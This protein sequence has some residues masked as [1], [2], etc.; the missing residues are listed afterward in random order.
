[1][2]PFPNTIF[3]RLC[4]LLLFCLSL[5]S[6]SSELDSENLERLLSLSGIDQQTTD[7]A[8]ATEQAL[9][10]L[11][12]VKTQ[13]SA[14]DGA[15]NSLKLEISNPTIVL[16][17]V[18]AELLKTLSNEEAK[19]L[20]KWFESPVGVK[21]ARARTA[22]S[23]N[24][25]LYQQDRNDYL[26][27]AGKERAKLIDE[28]LTESNMVDHAM[29]L[30]ATVGK[31]VAVVSLLPKLKKRFKIAELE[32]Q[33][34][35]QKS[36]MRKLLR[37]QLAQSTLYAYRELTDNELKQHIEMI[38]TPAVQ[39]FHQAMTDGAKHSYESAIVRAIDY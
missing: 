15:V 8:F 2:D 36:Y 21:V 9:D 38:K 6:Q 26:R 18:K 31:A 39:R 7:L 30:Q 35:A 19:S 29:E 1:M 11:P 10:R 27:S 33:I 23:R 17:N 16:G 5:P 28:L 12:Q 20:I 37:Q 22:A 24:E 3:A 4:F 25:G 34:E 32:K 13:P 14:T